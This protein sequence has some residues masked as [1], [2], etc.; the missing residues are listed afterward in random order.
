MFD[1]RGKLLEGILWIGIGLFICFLALKFEI[2]SFH[3]PGPGFL[4]LITGLFI[5]FMG[6]IL[7]ITQTLLKRRIPGEEKND[8]SFRITSFPRLIYTMILLLGYIIFIEPLGFIL[9]TFFLMF[10]LFL[11]FE[12]KNYAGSLF[13]SCITSLLSYLIFEIWLR[14]QLPKGIFPRW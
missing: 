14:C 1:K 10:G 4:P 8:F 13:F 6:M 9:S 11:D 5:F 2:G 12:K 3:S 7:V